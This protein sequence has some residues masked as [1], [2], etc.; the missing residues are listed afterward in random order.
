MFAVF[1]E[2][3]TLNIRAKKEDNFYIISDSCQYHEIPDIADDSWRALE[4]L[5]E[6][7]ILVTA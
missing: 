6:Q 3:K 4:T 1:P 2:I 5:S 7:T